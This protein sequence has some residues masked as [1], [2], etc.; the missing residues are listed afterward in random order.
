M[1][2][3]WSSAYLLNCGGFK[4]GAS[5]KGNFHQSTNGT[6]QTLP[7]EEWIEEAAESI[8]H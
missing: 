4:P 1:V 2:H 6:E 3:T 7:W 8:I 5:G